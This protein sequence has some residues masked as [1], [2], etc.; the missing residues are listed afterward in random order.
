MCRI[1]VFSL[2][3]G[4][5][6]LSGGCPAPTTD[7]GARTKGESVADMKD[8]EYQLATFGGG[9][10]WCVEAVMEQLDGVVDARSGYM[11]G[12]VANP[13]YEQI[14][15]KTT[16]HIE[17]VQ[18]TFDPS[19]VSYGTLLEW[20]FKSHDPTTRDQQGADKGPQYR[21]AIFCH[22]PEQKDAAQGAIKKIDASDAF[23]HPVVTEVLDAQKLWVAEGYHQD[24]YRNNKQH[25]YC[26]VVIAPKLDK[27]GLDK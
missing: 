23:E 9:C 8:G 20:F 26:Q 13:T 16:G 2:V 11:G 6:L 25:G 24:F 1:L 21:S 4:M 22:S 17:V 15:T 7:G 3:V 14:C 19:K 18:V 27:L 5:V 10:F 12:H